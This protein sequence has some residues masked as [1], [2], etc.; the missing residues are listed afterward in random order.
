MNDYDLKHVK[1]SEDNRISQYSSQSFK[2]GLE[3]ARKISNEKMSAI[4]VGNSDSVVRYSSEKIWKC[5]STIFNKFPDCLQHISVSPDGKIFA[6]FSDDRLGIEIWD[7]KSQKLIKT[8][9]C[10][11]NGSSIFEI[12]SNSKNIIIFEHHVINTRSLESGELLSSLE[13]MPDYDDSQGSNYL[14]KL[15]ESVEKAILTNSELFD[16]CPFSMAISPGLNLMASF[17]E[18]TIAIWNL[19]TGKLLNVLKSMIEEGFQN[20]YFANDSPILIVGND[21]T[22]S[23]HEIWNPID[24]TLLNILD[25]HDGLS[26]CKVSYDGSLLISTPQFYDLPSGQII[27][28]FDNEEEFHLIDLQSFYPGS[29]SCS[30]DGETLVIATGE[31]IGI[32]DNGVIKIFQ[33]LSIDEILATEPED[34]EIRGKLVHKLICRANRQYK[35]H[36]Y[37]KA[38]ESY[39]TA[40]KIDPNNTEAYNRRSTARS[41]IGDYQGAMEDLQQVRMI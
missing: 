3:L 30:K 32:E 35:S 27:N 28:D 41:A 36:D 21:S 6:V 25:I 16:C 4:S 13:C 24:G 18:N 5:V 15:D 31:D 34:R 37:Q 23:N 20:L 33:Q 22:Y 2:K 1:L 39:T 9:C 19:K 17:Y 29:S 8:I 12:T 26:G 7:I 14:R 11:L 38:I 40:L 10:L